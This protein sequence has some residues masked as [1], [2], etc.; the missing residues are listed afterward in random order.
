MKQ[1]GNTASNRRFNPRNAKPSIPI[2]VD[3]VDGAMERFIR[4]KYEHR[5]FADGE[6]RNGTRQNTR[7]TSAGSVDDSPPPL[8]PK[9]TKR[10]NFS[11]RA[12]SST[13]PMSR[14]EKMSPP[15]SPAIG[16]FRRDAS[17]PRV[18]K[19]SR[20]FGTSVGGT[21]D[22]FDLKL[23]TLREM[24]FQDSKR[25]STVLKGVNGDLDNAVEV[26]IRLGEGSK[27]SFRAPTPAPPKNESLNGI[28]IEKTRPAAALSFSNNPFDGLESSQDLQRQAF[29]SSQPAQANG[30]AQSPSPANPYNPFLVPAQQTPLPQQPLE[31]SFQSLQISEQQQPPQ[32]LPQQ[33]LFPNSTGGYG[34]Q[35]HYQDHNNPYMNSFAPPPVPQLVSQYTTREQTMHQPQ[36]QRPQH[37]QPTRLSSNP[38]LRSARSQG[39]APNNPFD[40]QSIGNSGYGPPFQQQ[41]E[42]DIPPQHLDASQ[43]PQ[44]QMQSQPQPQPQQHPFAPSAAFP[45]RAQQQPYPQPS[46]YQTPHHPAPAPHPH[47]QPPSARYDKTS[48]LALYNYPHL[49][50]SRP[51]PARAPSAD[52]AEPP[53][54][55]PPKQRAVTMPAAASWAAPREPAPLAGSHNPFAAAAAAAAPAGADNSVL[56]HGSNG[57]V[58]FA[59]G[60]MGGRHS[61]DAFAGLSARFV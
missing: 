51:P 33:Q 4:Q 8:P 52:A 28:T 37:P 23:A 60:L 47:Q 42:Q 17:P 16:G 12:A 10:F 61:P 30:G 14:S 3:E 6:A 29:A 56:R 58:D 43:P 18:N 25:N 55:G 48:I 35:P 15:V 44:P 53:L 41:T 7:S 2:D 22:N 5:A 31:L 57:S 59:A 11:L 46:L 9:P 32:Q 54:A 38:F 34:N 13:F 19:A 1:T 36:Q 50:P 26:L 24:G 20:V 49:A 40:Y 27:S 45:H 39:F 21:S